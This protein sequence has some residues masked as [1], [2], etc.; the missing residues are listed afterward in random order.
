MNAEYTYAKEEMYELLSTKDK[1]TKSADTP[2]EMFQML[3][4]SFFQNDMNEKMTVW[5]SVNK[6]IYIYIADKEQNRTLL[7]TLD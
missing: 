6:Y 7:N 3:K 1:Q 4:L 2:K 5:T